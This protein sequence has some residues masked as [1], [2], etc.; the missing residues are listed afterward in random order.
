M[1]KEFEEETVNVDPTKTR[2]RYLVVILYIKCFSKQLKRTFRQY[3]PSN[4]LRK[5]LV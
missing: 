2:M 4:R 5:M 3:N 1:D